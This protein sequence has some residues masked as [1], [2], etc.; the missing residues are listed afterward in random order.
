MPQDF[1]NFRWVRTNAPKA[2]RRTDDIWFL[3]DKVGWA[4]NSNGQIVK[5]ENGF[6]TYEVQAHFPD[7]WLRCVAFANTQ[8]GWVGSVATQSPDDR[9][10]HTTNGGKIWSPVTNLPEAAPLRVC[11]LHVVDENTVFASGTNYPNEKAAVVRTDNGG[12]S[13]T[14]FDLHDSAALLVDVY[15]KDRDEGW[16]V[17]GENVVKHPGREPVR[18]DVIPVVLHTK[19]GGRTWENTVA[20]IR[21]QF[22]RGEWGWKI[23]ALGDGTMFVSLE[24][25]RDGAL[26]RSDDGGKSWRRFRIND[27]NRNSNL[28]GIGFLDRD[29]GWVGGWGDLEFGG[30]YTSR[31]SDGGNNWDN[32]DDVGL[33]LNRFRFIGNPVRV[34]FASGDTVYKFTDKPPVHAM[35]ATVAE[36]GAELL[37]GETS[38]TIPFEVPA[39]AKRLKVDVWERFGRHVR[40]LVDEQNPARGLRSVPWDFLDANGADV[41]VGGYIARVTL[42][43]QSSSVLVYRS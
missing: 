26:L 8:V 7:L 6:D 28:E 2:S 42:D 30:G 18:D 16:V 25:L 9:L 34:A 41:A 21:K 38:V 31:T 36:A 40:R 32:A 43:G 24:N 19:D 10:F 14:A 5:T 3:D 12:K 20:N 33:R 22:P 4:V 27:R 23:Q 39:N 37:K 35:A 13:W 15:F 11:G 29:R 17:G 1:S